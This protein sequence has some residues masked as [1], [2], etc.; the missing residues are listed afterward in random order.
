M[1]G[2]EPILKIIMEGRSLG[3]PW[4]PFLSRIA[5]GRK[6]SGMAHPAFLEQAGDR[7]DGLPVTSGEEVEAE[8]NE[9]GFLQMDN[10]VRIC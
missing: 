1:V 6:V 10:T 9:V 4:P 8:V 2:M 7:H 3:H 5:M